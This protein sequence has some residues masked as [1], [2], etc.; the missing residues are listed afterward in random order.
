MP[1][2]L[3]SF[4]FFFNRQIQLKHSLG[5]LPIISHFHSRK[6]RWRIISE[7]VLSFINSLQT[8]ITK[9]MKC[10]NLLTVQMYFAIHERHN[11]TS[12]LYAVL[13][14]HLGSSCLIYMDD[15][16]ENLWSSAWSI[17]FILSNWNNDFYIIYH[18][19]A[20]HRTQIKWVFDLSFK[21]LGKNKKISQVV[22]KFL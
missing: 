5:N 12:N 17:N 21:R 1:T 11:Q 16:A 18:L 13:V 9:W 14:L 19:N 7:A 10:N 15:R 3:E 22:Y 20:N 8:I 4:F 2:N 6:A